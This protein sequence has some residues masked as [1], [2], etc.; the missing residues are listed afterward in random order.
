MAKGLPSVGEVRQHDACGA[1]I[2][3]TSC[4]M[5]GTWR[6]GRAGGLTKACLHLAG[7]PGGQAEAAFMAGIVVQDQG[8]AAIGRGGGILD[9]VGPACR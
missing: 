1:F 9:A 3:Q 7:E 4:G 5:L 8:L 2:S 6:A